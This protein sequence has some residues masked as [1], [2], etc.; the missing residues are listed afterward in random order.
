MRRPPQDINGR[1]SLLIRLFLS[2]SFILFPS[3]RIMV[4]G[5][6]NQSLFV[7]IKYRAA[8]AAER[9]WKMRE[10]SILFRCCYT[11]EFRN[12]SFA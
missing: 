11:S 3:I 2:L 9:K 6:K 10:N 8:G 7:G 12:G 5:I 4:I 1:S